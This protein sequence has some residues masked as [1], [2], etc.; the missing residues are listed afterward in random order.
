MSTVLAGNE[1]RMPFCGNSSTRRTSRRSTCPIDRQS[2]GGDA[3][4][5]VGVVLGAPSATPLA[6][7]ATTVKA[8]VRQPAIRQALMV[9][10]APRSIELSSS[11]S[12]GCSGPQLVSE[13]GGSRDRALIAAERLL[14]GHYGDTLLGSRDSGV[15]ELSGQYW[16]RRPR[17]R[18]DH[19]SE[20]G[21]LALVDRCRPP[22]I[23]V[24]ELRQR[25]LAQALVRISKDGNRPR[26]HESDVAVEQLVEIVVAGDDDRS[27]DVGRAPSDPRAGNSRAGDGLDAA[28]PREDTERSEPGGAKDLDLGGEAEPF[29]GVMVIT[30][31]RLADDFDGAAGHRLLQP[32]DADLVVVVYPGQLV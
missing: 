13:P 32:R 5:P 14:R 15:K 8:T 9:L 11:R 7:P 27:P 22:G 29:F 4:V 19:L 6:P 28:G 23:D 1:K 16:R 18:D 24:A 30:A 12:R 25:K 26:D 17:E 21:S 3:A 2:D 31:L 10:I 20:L